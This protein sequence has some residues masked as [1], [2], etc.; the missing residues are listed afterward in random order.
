MQISETLVRQIKL[1]LSW[2]A[3]QLHILG[4]DWIL[5]ILITNLLSCFILVNANFSVL[6]ANFR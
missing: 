5:V 4:V 3:G 1:F 2:V 6:Y